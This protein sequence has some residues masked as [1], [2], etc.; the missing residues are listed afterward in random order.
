M[1]E[2]MVGFTLA[3]VQLNM[4]ISFIRLTILKESDENIESYFYP[5]KL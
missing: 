5:H 3:D 2:R 4:I 1:V